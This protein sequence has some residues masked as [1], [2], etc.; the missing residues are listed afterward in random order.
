MAQSQSSQDPFLNA[1]IR[2][3]P[4]TSLLMSP[5]QPGAL[6]VS[7]ER[8]FQQCLILRV[9]L[10]G[11]KL[12]VPLRV[13][14]PVGSSES[15][16]A[17]VPQEEAQARGFLTGLLTVR[18]PFSAGAPLECLCQWPFGFPVWESL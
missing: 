7:M 16:L 9:P 1:E 17:W 5:S 8:N 14:Q 15:D 18:E 12:Q 13:S 6:C 4:T 2:A 3:H 11:F 10:K